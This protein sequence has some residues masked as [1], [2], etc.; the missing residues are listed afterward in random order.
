MRAKGAAGGAELAG[1]GRGGGH[2]RETR[3][4]GAGR[5]AGPAGLG[6]GREAAGRGRAAARPDSLP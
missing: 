5:L 1:W 2:W 3:E 4:E 6:S